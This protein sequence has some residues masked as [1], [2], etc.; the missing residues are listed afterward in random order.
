MLRHSLNNV[1]CKRRPEVAADLR[2]IYTSAIVEEAEWRVSEFQALTGA[3]RG[4]PSVPPVQH[5]L[6]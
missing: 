2:R 6:G 1:S 4:A 5:R 3:N